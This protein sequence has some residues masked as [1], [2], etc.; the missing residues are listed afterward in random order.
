MKIRISM[1]DEPLVVEYL[2]SIKKRFESLGQMKA[3]IIKYW[4]REIKSAHSEQDR[5]I[6]SLI[7]VEYIPPFWMIVPIAVLALF[8]I[9]GWKWW[10]MLPLG[11]SLVCAYIWSPLWFITMFKAGLRKKGYTGKIKARIGW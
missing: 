11:F 7:E 9:F 2:V 4:S 10:F 5:E 1:N 6:I 8:I 3:F